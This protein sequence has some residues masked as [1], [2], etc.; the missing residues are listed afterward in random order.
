MRQKK[1]FWPKNDDEKWSRKNYFDITPCASHF[2]FN[3]ITSQKGGFLTK[4]KYS[5]IK[6]TW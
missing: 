5:V 3:E 1:Y 4:S 2:L 6:M